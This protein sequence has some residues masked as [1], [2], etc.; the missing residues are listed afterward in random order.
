MNRGSDW[1]DDRAAGGVLLGAFLLG[2]VTA[3]VVLFSG[4]Q[5]R[6]LSLVTSAV[7]VL[8]GAAV[9]VML[10]AYG[11]SF[12]SDL[13]LFGGIPVTFGVATG[14]LALRR[15]TAAPPR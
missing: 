14:L 10:S 12:V 1:P 5:A 6:R 8:G 4:Y 2:A 9:A 11:P 13:L 3:A 15:A 7:F